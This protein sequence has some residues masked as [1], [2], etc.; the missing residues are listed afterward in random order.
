MTSQVGRG[1]GEVLS[2]LAVSNRA[3]MQTHKHFENYLSEADWE[4]MLSNGLSISGKITRLA[5]RSI[6]LLLFHPTEKTISS[7]VGLLLSLQDA[8]EYDD[9]AALSAVRE[10]KSAL[11][12]KTSRTPQPARWPISYPDDPAMFQGDFPDVFAVAYCDG[13]PVPSKVHT[14]AVAMIAAK[15]CLGQKE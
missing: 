5:S 12:P 7:I 11:R 3:P 9:V 10:F 1:D 15:V 14:S 8:S 4:V 13:L 6:S 2:C